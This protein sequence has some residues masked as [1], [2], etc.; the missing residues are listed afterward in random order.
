MAPKQR[1]ADWNMDFGFHA[2]SAITNLPSI[3]EEGLSSLGEESDNYLISRGIPKEILSIENNNEHNDLKYVPAIKLA[4]LNLINLVDE[5]DGPM[6]LEYAMWRSVEDATELIDNQTMKSMVVVL[7]AIRKTSPDI[8][9]KYAAELYT[10][11]YQQQDSEKS[12]AIANAIFSELLPGAMNSADDAV[13]FEYFKSNVSQISYLKN[14]EQWDA[15]INYINGNAEES[16]NILSHEQ[17]AKEYESIEKLVYSAAAKEWTPQ[18]VPSWVEEK[19]N[20]LIEDAIK[21]LIEQGMDIKSIED[22]ETNN[23][24][25]CTYMESFFAAIIAEDKDVAPVLI[26]W[27]NSQT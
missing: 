12:K 11:I 9:K 25:M 17:I 2:T 4:Q 6:I 3:Y 19:A 14:M 15:C 7:K 24:A 13:L 20:T 5:Q 21:D 27:L 26:R 1:F 8:V 22:L 18:P 23:K 16:F 10:A